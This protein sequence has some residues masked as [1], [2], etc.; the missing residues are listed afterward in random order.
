M[1][2]MMDN[3]LLVKQ[4]FSFG[5]WTVPANEGHVFQTSDTPMLIYQLQK[6]S[7]ECKPR[8]STVRLS[9]VEQDHCQYFA[10]RFKTQFR[11]RG[12][13]WHQLPR[14]H[15]S[16]DFICHRHHGLG[17][18]PRPPRSHTAYTLEV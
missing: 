13:S 18:C 1:N 7:M 8:P 2:F 9:L 16:K 3:I 15:C 14:P 12:S 6:S 5:F 10:V 17:R 11:L 4:Y